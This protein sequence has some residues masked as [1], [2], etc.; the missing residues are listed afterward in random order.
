M[1]ELLG[2]RVEVF[3]A[4]RRKFIF[5]RERGV[6]CWGSGKEECTWEWRLERD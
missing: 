2:A 4:N 3:R 1:W 6:L 5:S